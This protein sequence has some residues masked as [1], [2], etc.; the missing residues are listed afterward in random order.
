MNNKQE[1]HGPH[2]SPEKQFQAINTFAQK[3]RLC[4]NIKRKKIIVSFL[5]IKLLIFYIKK[6]K[7]SLLYFLYFLIIIIYLEKVGLFQTKLNTLLTRML[8][9]KFGLNWPSGSG[10]KDFFNFANEFLLFRYY[11][12]LKRAWPFI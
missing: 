3:Q 2:R 6:L 4:H 9:A 8:C 11:L 7:I 5:R 10:E 1:V 12:P